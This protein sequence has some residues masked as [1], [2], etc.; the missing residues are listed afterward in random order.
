MWI[1]KQKNS[2]EALASHLAANVPSCKEARNSIH[3]GQECRR[4]EEKT[5]ALILTWSRIGFQTC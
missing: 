1:L 2:S 3:G 5:T 4:T